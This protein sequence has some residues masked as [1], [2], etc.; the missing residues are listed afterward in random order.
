MYRKVFELSTRALEFDFLNQSRRF[1]YTW[2]NPGG[3]APYAIEYWAE[4]TED[5]FDDEIIRIINQEPYP[6]GTFHLK[7]RDNVGDFVIQKFP[8]YCKLAKPTAKEKTSTPE[9]Y[10][11]RGIVWTVACTNLRNSQKKDICACRVS[12]LSMTYDKVA[13]G[14][15]QCIATQ[16]LVFEYPLDEYQGDQDWWYDKI[17]GIAPDP[18]SIGP[19]TIMR[20]SPMSEDSALLGDGFGGHGSD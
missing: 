4:F 3:H 6:V 12:K 8:L 7:W 9:E 13:W 19:N 14:C 15:R 16:K 20:D 5:I 11:G 1:R 18:G 10:I 17:L 2:P